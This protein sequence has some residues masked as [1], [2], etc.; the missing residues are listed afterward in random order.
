MS[1]LHAKPHK[2]ENKILFYM[3]TLGYALIGVVLLIAG[4]VLYGISPRIYYFVALVGLFPVLMN[5]LLKVWFN[6]SLIEMT[7]N[8][9]NKIKT[10]VRDFIEEEE[11]EDVTIAL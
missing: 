11:D 9:V 3:K 1:V 2:T 6:I 10:A 8:Y 4:I 7:G 5:I